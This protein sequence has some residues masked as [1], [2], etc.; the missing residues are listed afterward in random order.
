MNINFLKKEKKFGG[1][2]NEKEMSWER[3]REKNERDS[4][5]KKERKK[6]KVNRTFK[7]IDD[8]ALRNKDKNRVGKLNRL[9]K[10]KIS[11]RMEISKCTDRWTRTMEIKVLERWTRTMEI[12]VYRQMY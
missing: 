1:G 7:W 8:Y 9:C 11:R 10:Y 2:G 5:I 6:E 12:K 3:K 4:N